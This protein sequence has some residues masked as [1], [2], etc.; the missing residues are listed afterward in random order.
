MFMKMRRWNGG[1]LG[2][3]AGCAL[4]TA[5]GTAMGEEPVYLI[6][7]ADM[8]KNTDYQIVT[9]AELKTLDKDIQAETK[10]FPQALTAAAKDWRTDDLYKALPFPGS[11]LGPR[12]IIGQPERFTKQEEAQK[13]LDFYKEA[14]T[15]R[16]AREAEKLEALKKKDQKAYDAQMKKE[17]DLQ[18]KDVQLDKVLE[19]IQTHLGELTGKGPAPEMP[20]AGDK[21]AQKPAPDKEKAGKALDKGL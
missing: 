11:R 10:F 14:D 2:V 9:S 12:K 1:F 16:A 17:K 3:A 19:M 13:K 18:D 4:L 7:I 15:K 6:K 21:P 20:D 5:V 8:K